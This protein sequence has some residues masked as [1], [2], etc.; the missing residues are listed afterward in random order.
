MSDKCNKC[1]N[2]VKGVYYCS[3]CWKLIRRKTYEKK[4]GIKGPKY[5][6]KY[7]GENYECKTKE[8]AS[9]IIGISTSAIYRIMSGKVKYKSPAG[10]KLIG[11][12]IVKN[13]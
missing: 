3:G 2:E 13:Y 8:E 7:N 6:I 5:T 12:E 11:I 4:K 10:K 1:E 9:E